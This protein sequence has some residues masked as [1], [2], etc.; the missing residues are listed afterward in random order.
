MAWQPDRT[1]EIA[2]YCGKAGAHQ[3][4]TSL[5][6]GAVLACLGLLPM[7]IGRLPNRRRRGASAIWI[8]AI[9]A[10]AAA[11]LLVIAVSE[12]MPRGTV[13]DL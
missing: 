11:A 10:G 1:S 7:L 3:V 6:V 8:A 12:Y 5:T 9:L 4:R 13:F 2:R